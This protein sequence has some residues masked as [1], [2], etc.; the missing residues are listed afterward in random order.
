[1]ASKS[2]S[3]VFWEAR[4]HHFPY[5]VSVAH[6]SDADLDP[7]VVPRIIGWRY[8]FLRVPFNGEAHWGFKDKEALDIFKQ[9]ALAPKVSS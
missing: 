3:Q 6:M 9:V 5:Q 7:R 2:K 8:K 4:N 1:M